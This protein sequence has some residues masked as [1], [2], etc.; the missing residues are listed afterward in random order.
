MFADQEASWNHLAVS[1]FFPL[2]LS[3][4]SPAC[5]SHY[6]PS[7]DAQENGH[8]NKGEATISYPKDKAVSKVVL[9]AFFETTCPFQTKA[10]HD[11]KT[12]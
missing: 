9:K 5:L 10:F 1:R 8:L 3:L 6:F 11:I 12:I 7:S 4:G 2:R